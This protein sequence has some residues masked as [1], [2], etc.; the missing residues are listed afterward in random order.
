MPTLGIVGGLGPESTIDYYRRILEA[1]ERDHPDSAPSIV[2]DSLDVRRAL[3]LVAQDRPALTEYLLASLQR[4]AAAG[5]DFIAMTAN[6][7][8]IIFDELAA[9]S[10]VPLLSIVE[11]C[12][13][14]AR[15]R[16][17][18]RLAL[19]G[20]R[21]TMEAPFY[22]EV[23]ARFG[24]AVVTPDEADRTW[25]HERYVEQLLRGEFRDDTRQEFISLVE[26]LRDEAGVEGVILGGTELPLL[27]P[28]PQIAELPA[29]DTTALHV[30][31]IVARLQQAEARESECADL[32]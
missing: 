22:P 11:V 23:C 29:L 7:P 27:L 17:L 28:T 16:G 13:E 30:A 8:H 26:R 1:W 12:A 4:L 5:A 6:T 2:I 25:V 9:R 31:A 32:T 24:I 3:R 20:T 18:G 10:P 21:F 14:E 15:R 19:L